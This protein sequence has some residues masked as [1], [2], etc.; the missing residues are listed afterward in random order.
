M[1]D[2][3]RGEQSVITQQVQPVYTVM[4][5]FTAGSLCSLVLY[6]LFSGWAGKASENPCR[7]IVAVFTV[8]RALRYGHEHPCR[9]CGSYVSACHQLITWVVLEVVDS[10]QEATTPSRSA[11]GVP[12]Q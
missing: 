6:L 7:K 3:Q 12:D 4:H 8:K 2:K 5:C 11:P 10:Q 1:I 9:S